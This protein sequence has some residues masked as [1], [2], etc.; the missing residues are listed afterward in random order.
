MPNLEFLGLFSNQL[1][2]FEE[3]VAILERYQSLTDLYIAGNPIFPINIQQHF[4]EPSVN[5]D[6]AKL[7]ITKL[8]NLKW[9]NGELV[10]NW[11]K[12]LAC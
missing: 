6:K 5:D 12:K 3:T 4:M 7:L 9:L 1:S 11:K 10:S 2:N 8:P